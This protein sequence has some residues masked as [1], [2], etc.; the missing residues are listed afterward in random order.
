M[1]KGSTKFI[2]VSSYDN[3]HEKNC[4]KYLNKL[5]L[6]RL[7]ISQISL[8]TCISNI[9]LSEV[10]NITSCHITYL[11]SPNHSKRSLEL[12]SIR[13]PISNPCNILNVSSKV[14]FSSQVITFNDCFM[15]DRPRWPNPLDN[16]R[17]YTVYSD[18]H[19]CIPETR[20]INQV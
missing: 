4:I 7:E 13:H 20:L 17:F 11:S 3:P 16:S 2:A 5:S 15:V 12:T 9:I 18:N 6:S 10:S 8:H 1:V 14:S 19:C